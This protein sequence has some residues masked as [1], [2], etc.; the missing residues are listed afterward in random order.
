MCMITGNVTTDTDYVGLMLTNKAL[1]KVLNDAPT[2]A[3]WLAARKGERQACEFAAMR[4]HRQDVFSSLLV[5]FK[6]PE[7]SALKPQRYAQQR[8]QQQQ[9]AMDTSPL[10]L[11]CKAG[12][13]DAVRRLLPQ[14][15]AFA[16][17]HVKQGRLGDSRTVREY[18]ACLCKGFACLCA[19]DLM[20]QAYTR[21]YLR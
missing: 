14:V 3:A 2:L 16:P 13:E 11:A 7:A 4:L 19:I 1:H 21:T 17:T 18:C 8:Q 6:V 12:F 15:R 5:I 9:Q 20:C 10:H